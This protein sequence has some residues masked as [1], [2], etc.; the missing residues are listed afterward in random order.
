MADELTYPEVGATSDGAHP[1]GYRH[2]RVRTRVGD[3]GRCYRAAADAVLGWRMHRA[4][5]VEVDAD[6]PRAESGVRVVVGLGV[7]RLRVHG[8][9]R[10]VWSRDGERRAGFGYG[11]L[12][13]H[14]VRGEEAF[15]VEWRPDGSVWLTVAAFSL[16]AVW[17]TRCAGPLVPVFQRAYARRC[18]RVLRRLAAGG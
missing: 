4:M 18:G 16:P 13:G 1:A 7:A 11:T 10:V 2:L 6:G 14:P 9:C 12:P 3:G 8:P 5:G 15:T 17:W